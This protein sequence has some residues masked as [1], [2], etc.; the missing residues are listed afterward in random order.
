[1]FSAGVDVKGYCTYG[2]ERIV[3]CGCGGGREI[4]DRYLSDTL[5]KNIDF[6]LKEA[7][8]GD[9]GIHRYFFNALK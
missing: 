3:G 5:I 9:E 8:F 1:M 7:W 2:E 6:R 4:E